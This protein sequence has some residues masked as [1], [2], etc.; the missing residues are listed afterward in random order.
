MS[1]LKQRKTFIAKCRLM[2]DGSM[3]F[4][5]VLSCVRCRPDHPHPLGQCRAG[6]VAMLWR[7]ALLCKT[8]RRYL[9]TYKWADTAF[10]FC[11]AALQCPGLFAVTQSCIRYVWW[12]LHPLVWQ[13]VCDQL[14]G[15]KLCPKWDDS[16]AGDT[17]RRHTGIAWRPSLQRVSC[18][19][20]TFSRISS[21]SLST[22]WHTTYIYNV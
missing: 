10:W 18:S 13:C 20:K 3:V 5:F 8:R 19:Q 16:L 6:S 22:R 1:F 14:T 9:L 17:D 7:P 12:R 11:S 4:N 21:Q 2:W 15:C